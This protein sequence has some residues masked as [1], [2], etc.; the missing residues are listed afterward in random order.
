LLR[1]S[2]RVGKELSEAPVREIL[3]IDE[4]GNLRSTVKAVG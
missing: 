1:H 2:G 4:H 3:D